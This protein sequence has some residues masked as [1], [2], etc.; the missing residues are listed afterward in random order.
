MGTRGQLLENTGHIPRDIIMLFKFLQ[1]YAGTDGP[2]TRNQVM[3]ALAAYSRNYLLPEIIDE[4]DG[5]LEGE[6]IKLATQLL[7]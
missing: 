7:G 3:S 4:L 5:Y 2:M 1:E 6:H